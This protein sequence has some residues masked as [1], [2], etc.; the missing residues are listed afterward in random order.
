MRFIVDARCGSNLIA[1][2]FLREAG[3]I[4]RVALLSAPI[5]LGAAGGQSRALG[6]VRIVSD[7]LCGGGTEATVM[8]ETPSVISVGELWVDHGCSFS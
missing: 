3:L 5:A 1:V 8:P 7:K 6:A 4:N 2:R